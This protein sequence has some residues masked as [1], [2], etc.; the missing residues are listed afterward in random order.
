VVDSIYLLQPGNP[1]IE[2]N[3]AAYMQERD[4]QDLLDQH[5]ALLP[6]GQINPEAPAGGW[7]S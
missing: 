5:P 4:L 7:S 1:L 3:Q 2:V 6:G